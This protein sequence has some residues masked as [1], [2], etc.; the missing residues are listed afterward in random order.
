MGKAGMGNAGIA[1]NAASAVTAGTAPRAG[2]GLG[3]FTSALTRLFVLVV[4][5][6][7]ESGRVE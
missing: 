6:V 7:L 2:S 5:L 4:V 3:R 1:V